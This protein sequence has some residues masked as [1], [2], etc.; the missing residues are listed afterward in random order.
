MADKDEK[1]LFDRGR[2]TRG[3]LYD[4]QRS[5]RPWK[6]ETVMMTGNRAHLGPPYSRKFYAN[7]VDRRLSNKLEQLTTC[8]HAEDVVIFAVEH[9]GRTGICY[10]CKHWGHFHRPYSPWWLH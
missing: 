4:P 2:S 8:Q 3:G 7:S 6:S 1:R 10:Q 5:L 9:L